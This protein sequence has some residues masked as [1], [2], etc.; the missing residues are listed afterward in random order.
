MILEWDGQS[1]FSAVERAVLQRGIG[2]GIP[3]SALL[4]G[5]LYSRTP[6]TTS[7]LRPVRP[8]VAMV[9]A[10]AL[11]HPLDVP[12]GPNHLLF[13]PAFPLPF[14][15][16]LHPKA[17]AKVSGLAFKVTSWSPQQ[18]ATRKRGFTRNRTRATTRNTALQL[19]EAHTRSFGERC[20]GSVMRGEKKGGNPTDG[21]DFS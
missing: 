16:A 10:N 9:V 2:A 13:F 18:T 4:Y 17:R 5:L 14:E 15:L 8:G 12:F 6:C 19:P 11:N 3:R 7:W 21:Y 1:N 20:W